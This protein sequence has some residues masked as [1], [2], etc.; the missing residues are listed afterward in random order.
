MITYLPV[1]TFSSVKRDPVAVHIRWRFRFCVRCIFLVRNGNQ[2][3]WIGCAF[4]QGYQLR[5]TRWGREAER[6]WGD[7][8]R[9]LATPTWRSTW[10]NWLIWSRIGPASANS[11]N[12]SSVSIRQM[13][14]LSSDIMLLFTWHIL[15][16]RAKLSMKSRQSLGYPR[17]RTCSGPGPWNQNPNCLQRKYKKVSKKRLV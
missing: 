13:L 4:L 15:C 7:W 1:P 8:Q 9:N 3:K 11:L 5:F 12:R 2:Y 6:W 14:S 10:W 17:M 16:Y